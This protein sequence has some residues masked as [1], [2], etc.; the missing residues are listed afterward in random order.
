MAIRENHL[1]AKKRS[2]HAK[3]VRV[4]KRSAPTKRSSRAIHR[5]LGGTNGTPNG[6]RAAVS[7]FATEALTV[8][9]RGVRHQLAVLAQKQVPTIAVV[10]GEL[11]RGIPRKVGGSY[12]LDRLS[13]SAGAK[14]R[15][16]KR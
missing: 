15:T 1:S 8:F 12:V 6:V 3:A 13:R 2:A 7:P 14:H 4:P 10:D 11:V 9:K 16:A 5:P